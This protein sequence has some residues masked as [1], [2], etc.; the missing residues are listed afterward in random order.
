MQDPRST[1]ATV[2]S[3]LSRER[4]PVVVLTGAGISA[5]SGVPTFRGPEGYWR[6]GSVNYHPMELAT[7]STFQRMPDDV[8][9]WYLF[10]RGV[11]R[12]AQP[13]AAHEAVVRLENALGDRFTLITQN[14]DG[15]HRRAGNSVARTYQIHGHI[16]A[17]RCARECR[18]DACP[19]PDEV[20]LDWPKDRRLTDVE[21]GLLTCPHCGGRARPHV[22]WFDEY[23]DEARYRFESSLEVAARA[24]L[25]IVV[26]TTGSTNLPLQVG[27][28]VVR[29]GGAMIVV[30]PEPSPFTEFAERC[31]HGAFLEGTACALVPRVVDSVIDAV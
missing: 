28:T 14:I 20:P 10:R 4:G 16:D 8:W 7:F 25:L 11:C 18:L 22:L 5:E 31:A 27:A 13:N 29:R 12:R 23:Y 1:L 30:N 15:L 17:M 9:A 21:R 19:I 3:A 24:A 6:V 26:G 2:L